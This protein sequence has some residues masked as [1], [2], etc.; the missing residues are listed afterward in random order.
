MSSADFMEDHADA[1]QASDAEFALLEVGEGDA[2]RLHDLAARQ[3]ALPRRLA[4]VRQLAQRL[5]GPAT[6]STFAAYDSRTPD[7]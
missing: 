4:G 2:D 5:A 1:G 7:L 6:R 3:T